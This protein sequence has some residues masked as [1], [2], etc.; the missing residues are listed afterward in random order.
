MIARN[1]APGKEGSRYGKYDTFH[2]DLERAAKSSKMCK[3]GM[4][5]SVHYE[6]ADMYADLA[7]YNRG[8]VHSEF[9]SYTLVFK[10]LP[11][12]FL[13]TTWENRSEKFNELFKN[14]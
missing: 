5:Q 2:H 8:R 3:C 9:F 13:Y 11:H 10:L 7:D 1:I 6:L 12:S 4:P 14:K